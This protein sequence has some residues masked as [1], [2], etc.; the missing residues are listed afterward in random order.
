[1]AERRILAADTQKLGK[2]SFMRVCDVD[3][4]DALVTDMR[5]QD[6]WVEF[7]NRNGVTNL[8]Q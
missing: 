3:Q 4:I 6:E 2:K 1:M 5:P 7:C 8:Y